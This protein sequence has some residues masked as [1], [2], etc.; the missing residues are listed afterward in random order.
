MHLYSMIPQTNVRKRPTQIWIGA[1]AL[2]VELNTLLYVP[3]ACRYDAGREIAARSGS[4]LEARFV[5]GRHW[6]SN[7]HDIHVTGR[8][9]HLFLD[10]H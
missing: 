5:D 1:R 2:S 7:C 8:S 4:S 10:Q 9:I 3:A 6:L